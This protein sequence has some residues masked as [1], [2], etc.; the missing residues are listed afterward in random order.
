[1]S[2]SPERGSHRKTP[3]GDLTNTRKSDYYDRDAPE[4]NGG[5]FGGQPSRDVILEGIHADMNDDD[6]ATLTLNPYKHTQSLA[7]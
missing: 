2:R 7:F 3:P 5:N 6:V 4:N 1:V